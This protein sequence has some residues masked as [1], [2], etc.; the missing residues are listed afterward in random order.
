[1]EDKKRYVILQNQTESDCSNL[2]EIMLESE[3]IKFC[4]KYNIENL[5]FNCKINMAGNF[6][7]IKLNITDM[8]IVNEQ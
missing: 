4:Q 6:A 3:L 1:M 8:D 7:N 5:E 2:Q